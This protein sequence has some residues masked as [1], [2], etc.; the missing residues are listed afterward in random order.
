MALTPP[1]SLRARLV[2]TTLLAATLGAVVLVI[3]LQVLLARSNEAAMATSLRTRAQAAVATLVLD[4]QGVRV[5]EPPDRGFDDNVWFYDG[6]GRL[7][8]G[9]EPPAALAGAITGLVGRGERESLAGSYRLLA[10]PVPDTGAQRATVVVAADTAPLEASERTSLWLSLG[11]GAFA[12]LVACAAAWLAASRSLGQV[13]RM[14]ER[15][16]EWREH[17]LSRRFALA[18]GDEISELGNT[19]D[20]MLDRIAEALHSERRL[21]DEI[22][23][24]LRNPL[25]V[26]RGEAELALQ[27]G[28]TTEGLTG[29]VAAADRMRDALDTM[30][31]VA[32]AQAGPDGVARCTVG[33]LFEALGHRPPTAEAGR[34]TLAAPLAVL[35]AAL[36]PLLDN[37]HRH[38]RG[39]PHL[40]VETDG[41][42]AVIAVLDDGPGFASED[43]DRAFDP[44]HS[45][46]DSAGLGLPLAR[47]MAH[48][49]GARVEARPGPGGRVDLIV[50]VRD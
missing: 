41:R 24:E 48:A 27:G 26:I 1:A 49:T 23:H 16:D 34:L 12:V 39:E 46:H 22:A 31:E 8:D 15:A 40:A 50:P 3:G 21:T 17:D 38:G 7:V 4:P 47:R 11:L 35:V 32:R 28:A 43:V 45:T 25:S 37:A 18:G 6:Q 9:R 13:G 33:E 19:L 10:T 14:A 44:G 36:E 20:R 42:E 29:I 2:A 5:L 30:L